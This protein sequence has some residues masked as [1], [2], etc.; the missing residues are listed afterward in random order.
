MLGV[1]VADNDDQAVA[2]R[3]LVRVAPATVFVRRG[4][5]GAIALVL[6]ALDLE[7]APAA[8]APANGVVVDG[9]VE[10]EIAAC[11]AI[12]YFGERCADVVVGRDPRFHGLVPLLSGESV[13][14]KN[15]NTQREVLG[16]VVERYGWSATEI[17]RRGAIAC[18]ISHARRE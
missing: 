11:K 1:P 4:P 14:H 10:A 9:R 8:L 12:P 2:V 7:P 18:Q 17:S 5:D 16:Y 3:A 6:S 15:K 13:G